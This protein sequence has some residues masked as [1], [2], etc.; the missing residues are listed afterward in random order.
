MTCAR[1][2][3]TIVVSLAAAGCSRP[4]EV[5]DAFNADGRLIALSGGSAGAAN[6]CVACHGLKGEGDGNLA[7]RLA[8]RV[9]SPPL[10]GSRHGRILVRVWPRRCPR[11]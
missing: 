2:A 1:I 10:L 3:L 5:R 9:C 4:A 6:A 11:R 7:P 8:D